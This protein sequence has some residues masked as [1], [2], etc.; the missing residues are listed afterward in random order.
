MS[1]SLPSHSYCLHLLQ[2]G[3]AHL[4]EHS[5]FSSLSIA[6]YPPPPRPHTPFD[7]QAELPMAMSFGL[8][9]FSSKHTLA[10]I[11]H[12]HVHTLLRL[13]SSVNLPGLFYASLS[14]CHPLAVCFFSCC[15]CA[16]FMLILSA[17][18]VPSF[19]PPPPELLCIISHHSGSGVW[20]GAGTFIALLCH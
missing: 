19:A 9:V 7:A 3:Q 15:L 2:L 16:N 18:A 12:T 8:T 17:L 14:H 4:W 1:W 10:Q 20:A 13:I 5:A 6:P 11:T